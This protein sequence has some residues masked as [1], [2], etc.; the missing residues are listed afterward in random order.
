MADGL[1]R[2]MAR[3]VFDEGAP[4]GIHAGAFTALG[5]ALAS[6][7]TALQAL[8]G[9]WGPPAR[10]GP[11]SVSRALVSSTGGGSGGPEFSP[12]G[13]GAGQVAQGGSLGVE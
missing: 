9:P 3:G 10:P 7:Y 8:P 5:R 6:V 13:L 4:S 1:R 11:V 2:V 12:V